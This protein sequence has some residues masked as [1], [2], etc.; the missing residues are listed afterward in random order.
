MGTLDP[1]MGAL[2]ARAM[3]GAGIHTMMGTDVDAIVTRDG[4]V[5]SVRAGDREIPADIVILGLGVR[6][7][8]HLAGD[9]GLP[10]G[11]ADA[12]LTDRRMRVR[13]HEHIWA[14]G[15]CAA[16]H[17]RLLDAPVHIALGTHANKQG[18]VVGRNLTGEP[19]EFDGVIGT[20][21]TKICAREIARTGL[22]EGEAARAGR[23]VVT[24]DIAA[25]TRAGYF[26]GVSDIH[27]RMTADRG[28]RRILGAQ[29]VGGDGS[30]VRIDTIA[31]AIWRDMTVDELVMCDLAYAPPFS[32]VW[33]PVQTA[34]RRLLPLLA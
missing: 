7:R 21:I 3:Q 19:V 2:V 1:P 13:G 4:R 9:A 16:S 34:A 17:H 29:I 32:P 10:L 12:I 24:T 5:A 25:K 18:W 11:P 23:E 28:S 15:D 8:T 22:G 14:A 27:V 26:P 33:D 20:A 6:A 30:A 31:A